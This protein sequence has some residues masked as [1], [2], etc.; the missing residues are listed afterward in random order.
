[1]MEVFCFLFFLLMV[2]F[3]LFIQYWRKTF[4]S[5][6]TFDFIE[7]LSC[8]ASVLIQ[9][10]QKNTEKSIEVVINVKIV[11]IIKLQNENDGRMKSI[12]ARGEK[13][14]KNESRRQSEVWLIC[15]IW[16]NMN[17]SLNVQW[18]YKLICIE[19]LPVRSS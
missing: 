11:F 17:S 16:M 19:M 1:M 14:R 3:L 2:F 7:F 8:R 13:N 18:V 5:F 10:F 9:V 12:F 6:P 4:S 15:F